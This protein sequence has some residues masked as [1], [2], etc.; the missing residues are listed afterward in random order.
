MKY[1]CFG[2]FDRKKIDALSRN[3]LD[4]LMRKCEPHL[5]GLYGSSNFLMDIGVKSGGVALGRLKGRIE[6]ADGNAGPGMM[7][8]IGNVF[9]IEAENM[10]EAIEAAKMHPALSLPEGEAF[11][12]SVEIHEVHTFE[13]KRGLRQRP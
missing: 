8:E 11:G 3:E 2:L 1:A 5:K 6:R 12:W 10:E 7:R 9:I 4:E 13:V